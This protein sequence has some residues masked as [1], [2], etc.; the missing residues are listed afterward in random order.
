[1]PRTKLTIPYSQ[2]HKIQSKFNNFEYELSVILP[3]E[4]AHNN[5][6]Y[7]VI[8]TTDPDFLLPLLR[9]IASSL[10]PIIPKSIIVGIG[11]ANLDFLELSKNSYEEKINILRARDF[12][13]WKYNKSIRHL[14][15]KNLEIEA[16][17]IE[18]SGRAEAFKN[19]VTGEALPLIDK[20]YRTTKEKTLIG[21]SFGGIFANFLMLNYPSFFQNYLII[22]PI[23]NFEDGIVF[24]EM[25][26]L[27]KTT[28][29]KAYLAAGS[30]ESGYSTNEKFLADLKKFHEKINASPNVNSI[31]EI[32]T[33][34]YHA[35]VVPMA[36]SKGL[37]FLLS[38]IP[39]KKTLS[40]I[41]ELEKNNG[42]Q[43]PNSKK[44]FKNLNI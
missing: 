33:D 13:P 22:S 12:L 11:H 29:I 15:G 44:L 18:S 4:Y 3:P 32:F 9:G 2:T 21:H 31:I 24:N 43:V 30:L 16:K 36:L 8:F 6:N 38:K 7:P 35:S 17:T 5:N 37:R 26:N 39:N 27:S 25:N 42:E 34:E 1:M 10:Y 40:S 23:L 28:P 14:S 19:F 20:T 41:E